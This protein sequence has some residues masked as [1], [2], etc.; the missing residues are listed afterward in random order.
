MKTKMKIK[1]QFD[2]EIIKFPNHLSM[3]SSSISPNLV[4]S[5]YAALL[6]NK[7]TGP[8]ALTFSSVSFQLL[9]SQHTVVTDG[10]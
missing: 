6:T 2:K 8:I 9:K 10:N 4:S 1:S 3:V 5:E 7:S